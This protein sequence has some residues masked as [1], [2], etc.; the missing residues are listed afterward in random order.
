MFVDARRLDDNASIAADVCIIGGGVA[1]ITLALEFD[2][3]NIRTCVLESGGF[4]PD[5]AT[6]DLNRGESVGLPYRFDD[7]C[8]SRFLGGSS[9]CWGGW[10]RPMDEQDFA[11]RDWVPYSGWPFEKRELLPYYD[12]SRHVLKI[13]PDR[14]DP[15]FWFA[16]IGRTALRRIRFANGDVIDAISQFSPPLKFGQFY[17]PELRRSENVCVFLYAN[18]VEIEPD[19]S[20]GKIEGVK[21]A[22]LT[23]RT[24]RVVATVFILAAGG[25]ENA[26]LLL[27]SNRTHPAGLGNQHDLVG[28]FFMDH[29]QLFTGHVRFPESSRP[30]ALYD[31]KF[32][33]RNPSISAYGTCIA[34]QLMLSPETR[35]RHKLLNSLVSFESVF[36]GEISQAGETL[37]RLKRRLLQ[38]EP[39]GATTAGGDLL[40]V[41]AHPVDGAGFVASRLLRVRPL[42]QKIRLQLIVEPNPDPESR[43]T[44]SQRRDRLGMNRVRVR[45]VLGSL[46]KRTLDRTCALIAQEL[47]RV[48]VAEVSLDPPIGDGAWP[49]TFSDAGAWHHMGTTRMHDSPELGVVD[50]D[51]R[52]HGIGNL[53][54]CGS[55]VFPTAGGNF[56]TITIV[57]LALR[58][59]DYI[60]EEL[61]RPV[62]PATDLRSSAVVAKGLIAM[63]AP[64]GRGQ[65][66]A[67]D[68]NRRL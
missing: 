41:L 21:L 18:A 4:R 8:R 40:R 42:V 59:S 52:V 31:C 20:G 29:V 13:G 12:R 55:S 46:V 28:R 57:A 47:R 49:D 22:T 68:H 6:R 16:A 7:G 44:L 64:P 60:A 43:I 2:K 15:E 36:R 61:R 11:A 45:W 58:L 27:V 53:Y 5:H 34:A 56:P 37:V 9:N 32:N 17:K 1:G 50:R 30:Y 63:R 54:V 48:G 38:R 67:E 35:A 39:P 23:G 66:G 62:G 25:I 19:A 51:C 33:H 24:A 14:Y 65:S 26:R 10:C 3:R